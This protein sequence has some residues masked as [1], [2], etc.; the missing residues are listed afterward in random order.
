MS[1]GYC[2]FLGLWVAYVVFSLTYKHDYKQTWCMYCW[3][4]ELGDAFSAHGI[5]KER[6]TIT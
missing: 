4:K 1:V 3:I 6:R 2:L 5:P